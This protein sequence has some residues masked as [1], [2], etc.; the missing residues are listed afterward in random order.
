MEWGLL[1]PIV[2]ISCGPIAWIANTWIR[3]RHGYALTNNKG[4][5]RDHDLPIAERNRMA[6]LASENEEQ[7]AMI[8]KLHQRLAVLERIATD[9]AARIAADIDALR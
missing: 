2:A 5:V 8:A 7:R 6:A 1:V 9:P 4:E 3:A